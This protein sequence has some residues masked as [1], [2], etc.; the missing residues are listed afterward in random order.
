MYVETLNLVYWFHGIKAVEFFSAIE[1][2]IL[3]II[4]TKPLPYV[5]I[6]DENTENQLKPA[7][8]LQLLQQC[9][10]SIDPHK[11]QMKTQLEQFIFSEKRT[12]Q[13]HGKWYRLMHF[14]ISA[15]GRR[16]HSITI[17]PSKSN[18]DYAK[19]EQRDFNVTSWIIE[20]VI[21]TLLINF[22]IIQLRENYGKG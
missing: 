1:E 9:N 7:N 22:S 15:R 5:K 2:P 21:L 12:H 19:W 3:A 14:V 8:M 13:N 11:F 18:L 20:N 10:N 4:L 6:V 17:L 16:N